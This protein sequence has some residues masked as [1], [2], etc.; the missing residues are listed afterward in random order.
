MPL[1]SSAAAWSPPPRGDSRGACAPPA[2]AGLPRFFSA[3][4][5][6]TAPT[7]QGRKGRSQRNADD[8]GEFCCSVSSGRGSRTVRPVRPSPGSPPRPSGRATTGKGRKGRCQRKTLPTSERFAVPS[9]S[10]TRPGRR[11]N[12]GKPPQSLPGAGL[13]RFPTSPTRKRG[14][15]TVAVGVGAEVSRRSCARVGERWLEDAREGGNVPGKNFG[16]PRGGRG[17]EERGVCPPARL[18]GAGK[19]KGGASPPGQERGAGGVAGREAPTGAE[20]GN[21]LPVGGAF[22]SRPAAAR[23]RR[24]ALWRTR[25]PWLHVTSGMVSPSTA[26]PFSSSC[27]RSYPLSG[28]FFTA[29]SRDAGDSASPSASRPKL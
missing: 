29:A 13:P 28:P 19:R 7:G 10:V 4:A 1:P 17:G 20:A 2:S 24:P 22:Y 16:G 18:R 21:A 3:L 11:G 26:L 12:G 14:R 25:F 23:P 5:L 9:P 15:R 27:F 6:P 8:P